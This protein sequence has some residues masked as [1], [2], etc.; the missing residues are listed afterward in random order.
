MSR[1]GSAAGLPALW[2]QPLCTCRP[3]AFH[4]GFSPKFF[5]VPLLS[6]WEAS[7]PGLHT[8]L[9]LWGV[10]LPT[11]PLSGLGLRLTSRGP[12]FLFLSGASLPIFLFFIIPSL[13][14]KTFFPGLGLDS[15][16]PHVPLPFLSVVSAVFV[17]DFVQSNS[18]L[19]FLYILCSL[20]LLPLRGHCEA[21]CSLERSCTGRRHRSGRQ[22]RPLSFLKLGCGLVY[23]SLM[24]TSPFPYLGYA[25]TLLP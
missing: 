14:S 5:L 19:L 12:W 10:S 24:V 20:F 25:S 7:R 6:V 11:T 18:G 16:L 8:P 2:G 17:P 9:A 13:I 1:G 4:S 22:L 3:P 23:S 21:L 15:F